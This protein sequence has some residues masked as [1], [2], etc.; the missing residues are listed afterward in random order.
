MIASNGKA[1]TLELALPIFN[2]FSMKS[3]IMEA[4]V[5]T[6]YNSSAAVDKI[7][8][9]NNSSAA[10]ELSQHHHHQTASTMASMAAATCMFNRLQDTAGFANR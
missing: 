6:C 10:E 4:A 1:I 8:A 3:P 7:K 2:Y 9:E 5:P